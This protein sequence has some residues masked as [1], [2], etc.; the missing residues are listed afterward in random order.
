MLATQI[1]DGCIKVD[2]HRMVHIF[3][4]QIWCSDTLHYTL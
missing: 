1:E 4:V 2:L 3:E